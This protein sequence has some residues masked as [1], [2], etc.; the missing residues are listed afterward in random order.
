MQNNHKISLDE[1]EPG[2]IYYFYIIVYSQAGNW[3]SLAG[4]FQ[5]YYETDGGYYIDTLDSEELKSR[6][7]DPISRKLRLESPAAYILVPSLPS[8]DSSGVV[9]KITNKSFIR[10]FFEWLLALFSK[11]F[12]QFMA[13][14]PELWWQS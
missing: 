12:Y 6:S 13:Y 10:M 7:L 4:G 14:I 3:T 11:T 2:E 8:P 9:A 5:T 1:I